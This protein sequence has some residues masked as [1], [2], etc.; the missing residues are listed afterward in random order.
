MWL[1]DRLLKISHCPPIAGPAHYPFAC[2]SPF[3]ALFTAIDEQRPASGLVFFSMF[4]REQYLIHRLCCDPVA[5][6]S[7]QPKSLRRIA[8]HADAF[9]WRGGLVVIVAAMITLLV[10]LLQPVAA[11][12]TAFVANS[13]ARDVSTFST[14][15][16]TTGTALASGG[17]RGLAVSSDGKL[18]YAHVGSFV[19]IT[20]VA[21]D[22]VIGLIQVGQGGFGDLVL[23]PDDKFVYVADMGSKTVSVIDTETNSVVATIPTTQNSPR[24]L[25]VTPDGSKVFVSCSDGVAV[26]VIDT[27]TNTVSASVTVG[28]SPDGLAVTPDGAFVYVASATTQEVSKI[29]VADNSN[30]GAFGPNLG[31]LTVLAVTPDGERLYVASASDPSLAVFDVGPDT[32]LYKID[33]GASN[34]RGIAITPDGAFVYVTNLNANSTSVIATSSGSGAASDSL[35]T[36]VPAVQSPWDVV[37]GP[38]VT[39]GNPTASELSEVP[40]KGFALFSNAPN[41][42]RTATTIRYALDEAADVRMEIVDVQGRSVRALDDGWS[43]TGAHEITWDGTDAAGLSLPAGLYIVRLQVGSR[44]ESMPIMKVK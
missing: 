17:Q 15:D 22:T 26:D 3:L 19:S 40:E 5:K 34:H 30:V 12:M 37:I 35:V 6:V 29:N 39:G 41:P 28:V 20:D 13:G 8:M 42:F 14:D 9:S 27:A 25:V 2:V 10:G 21:A 32:L 18:L 31:E 11:Q 23:S 7:F 1:S 33:A 44:S 16:Y 38:K 24:G 4:L 36:M 43:N